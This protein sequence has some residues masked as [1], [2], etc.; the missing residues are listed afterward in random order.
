MQPSS[1]N[2]DYSVE[3]TSAVDGCAWVN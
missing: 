3:F 1:S 2:Q